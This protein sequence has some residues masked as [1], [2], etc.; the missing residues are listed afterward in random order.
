MSRIGKWTIAHVQGV[1]HRCF[2]AGLSD[3]ICGSGRGEVQTIKV[4]STFPLNKVVAASVAF[5]TRQCLAA[6]Q[7]FLLSVFELQH[8]FLEAQFFLRAWLR[9]QLSHSV[10]SSFRILH[11]GAVSLQDL[12][13]VASSHLEP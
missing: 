12:S 3:I 2:P 7:F 5:M 8:V 4:Q 6:K 9:G 10:Y 11:G 13:C 1:D